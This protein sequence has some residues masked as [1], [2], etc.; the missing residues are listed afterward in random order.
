MPDLGLA[1]V[2]MQL[3]ARIRPSG[4]ARLE[5]DLQLDSRYQRQHQSLT[6]IPKYGTATLH[7]TCC[8]RD[9]V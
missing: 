4:A 6:Q 5:A 8:L 1:H 9:S 7:N 3:S 2:G